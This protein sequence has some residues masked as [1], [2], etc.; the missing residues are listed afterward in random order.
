[1]NNKLV[2]ATGFTLQDP[3]I[4]GDFSTPQVNV[5]GTLS[6]TTQIITSDT[7][8]K[9]NI[10]PISDALPS[11]MRLEGVTY[12]WDQ[13]QYPEMPLPN[14]DDIGLLAQEVE[15][16]FPELVS[17]GEN[18]YKAIASHKLTA[19]LI[20]AVKEQQTQIKELA[21]ENNQLRSTL[22][23]QM[24]VLLARLAVLEGGQIAYQ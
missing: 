14:G 10:Q 11:L 15:Q 19:I 16:V 8:L 12:Q 3:L 9:K 7:R 4:T 13:E 22:T 18:G 21:E 1:M 5:M 20:E 23:E 2:I 6:V 17:E 24:S